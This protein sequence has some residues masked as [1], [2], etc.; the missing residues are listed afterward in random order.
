M[1]SD[2][3]LQEIIENNGDTSKQVSEEIQDAVNDM[4]RENK[5]EDEKL[6]S[7]LL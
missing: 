6:R 2:D 3:R 4:E 5:E 7:V 1:C